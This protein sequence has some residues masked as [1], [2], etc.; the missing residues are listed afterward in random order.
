MF[1]SQHPSSNHSDP[2][3]H[4][5]GSQWSLG[6]TALEISENSIGITEIMPTVI[7]KFQLDGK[8]T[9]D[10]NFRNKDQTQAMFVS[11]QRHCPL[12]TCYFFLARGASQPWENTDIEPGAISGLC[13]TT[14]VGALCHR[15]QPTRAKAEDKRGQRREHFLQLAQ[16]RQDSPWRPPRNIC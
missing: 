10:K 9:K 5:S 4:G 6:Q 2:K 3:L 12:P 16:Q 13:M 1:P 8:Q 14:E 7:P 15:S 11:A